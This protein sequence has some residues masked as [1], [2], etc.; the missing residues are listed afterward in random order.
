MDDDS[1]EAG[2]GQDCVFTETS[3]S[4]WAAHLCSAGLPQAHTEAAQHTL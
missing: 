1:C 2:C 4:C 3:G